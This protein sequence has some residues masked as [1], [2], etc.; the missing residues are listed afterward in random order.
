VGNN[1]LAS[2]NCIHIFYKVAILIRLLVVI[3]FSFSY[4]FGLSEGDIVYANICAYSITYTAH[5]SNNYAYFKIVKFNGVFDWT[6]PEYFSHSNIAYDTDHIFVKLSCAESGY[7]GSKPY[8]KRYSSEEYQVVSVNSCPPGSKL[9]NNI[10]VCKLP[11]WQETIIKSND[12]NEKYVLDLDWSKLTYFLTSDGVKFTCNKCFIKTVDCPIGTFNDGNQSC[13]KPTLEQYKDQCNNPKFGPILSLATESNGKVIQQCSQTVYCES[14]L[15]DK[16]KVSCGNSEE[17]NTTEPGTDNGSSQSSEAGTDNGSSQGSEA[18]TDNGSSQGSEAGTDN[19]SSQSSEAGTDNGS[20]QSSEAGTDNGSS[21]GSEAGTDNGS[22]QS[23]EAGTDNGSS[24]SCEAGTDR[25]IN[26]NY[27]SNK[28]D[29]NSTDS[30][31]TDTN[32]TN[33]KNG[34]FLNLAKNAINE[35][36]QKKY[37]ILDV[38]NPTYQCKESAVITFKTGLLSRDKGTMEIPDLTCEFIHILQKYED[39]VIFFKAL[40]L[41]IVAILGINDFFRR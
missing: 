3:F 5:C 1:N 19:G 22:S 4:L 30:P 16:I 33:D 18:G 31:G 23:Y 2:Y 29:S 26:V 10:C 6:D 39:V 24:Q 25:E 32:N 41:S 8:C 11:G 12:C 17:N 15:I 7:F 36:L 14:K 9:E 37:T 13:V 27:D 21:Q 28:T 34:T 38:K 40:I 35:I 20:S